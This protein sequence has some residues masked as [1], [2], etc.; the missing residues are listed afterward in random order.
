MIYLYGKVRLLTIER[1]RC[2]VPTQSPFINWCIWEKCTKKAEQL[3]KYTM[4]DMAG[5]DLHALAQC[6][7]FNKYRVLSQIISAINQ[8]IL[9][10]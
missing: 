10:K 1:D 5:S 3:L 2:K 4:Y 7:L 6:D 8:I 9:L